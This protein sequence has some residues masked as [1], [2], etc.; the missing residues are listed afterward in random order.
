MAKEAYY[1]SHDSNARS[2]P[3]ILEMR[4]VYKSMGYGWYWMIIELM[5]EQ[6]DYSLSMQGKYVW[7]A[8]A[9]QVDATAEEIKAFVEDCINEFKLFESDGT[10]FWSKSL[11]SRMKIKEDKS[12]KARK[13]A[14]ARWN[15]PSKQA[16]EEETQCE[17]NANASKNDAIKESKVKEIKVNILDGYT[18]NKDLQTAIKDF[19]DMRK[20]IKKPMTPRAVSLMLKE[21]DKL[22]DDDSKKIS[23]LNQSTQNSWLSVYALKENNIA[24]MVKDQICIPNVGARKE[25]RGGNY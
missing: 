5:R 25:Y 4:S 18:G 21:L 2:D 10:K 22:S 14:E 16:N 13:S 7:N 3:K 8:F 11:R 17:G 6:E 12:E 23:I 20:Q 24:S 15:K 1:F 19:I 9:L